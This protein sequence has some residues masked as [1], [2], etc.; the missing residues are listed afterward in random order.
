MNGP[1][2]HADYC[3]ELQRI[4]TFAAL[5]AEVRE[6]V[7]KQGRFK[8]LNAGQMAYG[9]GDP[10]TGIFLVVR[11][12]VRHYHVNVG[13]KQ[14]LFALFHPGDW[15]GELSELD[16]LPRVQDAVAFGDSV[17]LHLPRDRCAAILRSYPAFQAF[18]MQLLCGHLRRALEMLVEGKSFPIRNQVAQALVTLARSQGNAPRV[19]QEALAAMVGAS[20]QTVNKV[21]R[22]FKDSN[23]VE[24]KY[25]QVIPTNMPMLNAL[26]IGH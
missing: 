19:S 20:R 4:P 22:G 10:P 23:I 8:K 5:N 7:L 13:G 1:A 15:F 17:L 2:C 3:S 24:I 11:G 14:V 18:M 25:R 6:I 26:A 21:L 12:E 9:T 16:N